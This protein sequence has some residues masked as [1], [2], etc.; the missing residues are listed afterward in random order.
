MSNSL[1]SGCCFICVFEVFFFLPWQIFYVPFYHVDFPDSSCNYLFKRFISCYSLGF[2]NLCVFIPVHGSIHACVY[3]CVQ[4]HVQAREQCQVLSH[5]PPC[6]SRQ[7]LMLETTACWVIRSESSCSPGDPHLHLLKLGL[8]V[9]FLTRHWG[10]C[11]GSKLLRLPE[12][13]FIHWAVSLAPPQ[14][15]QS[16]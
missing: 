16:L 7:G 11:W 10:A 4:K 14:L 1:F 2:F 3:M 15:F 9:S 5:S 12:G 6:I 8:W 13:H